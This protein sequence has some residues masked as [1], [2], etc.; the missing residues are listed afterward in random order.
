MSNSYFNDFEATKPTFDGDKPNAVPEDITME[1]KLF[2]S[3]NT[4]DKVYLIKDGRKHWVMTLEVLTALGF[5]LGDEAFVDSL[6]NFVSG[7]PIKLSTVDQ[8]K[9]GKPTVL[10]PILEA[11]EE[12]KIDLV[13][14]DKIIIP[15]HEPEGTP[16]VIVEGLT[17][18]II[19][20]FI[21][22]YQ[23]LHLTG[24]C[25]GQ[26]E[27]HTDRLKTPYE[28][29]LVSNGGMKID[30]KFSHADKFIEN[31]ENL[32]FA[33][34]VNQGIRVAQGEFVVIMNNDIKVYEHW[35]EDM[36]EGLKY[37]DL[38]AAIPMYSREDPWLRGVDSKKLREEQMKLPIEES[39]SDFEDFS[40]VVVKR[41]VF[42]EIG[43][44]DERYFYS[45]E[46]VDFKRRMKEKGLTYA[47]SKRVRTHHVGSCTDF[48]DKPKVMDQSKQ[49]FAEKWGTK[50]GLA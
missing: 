44:F 35:L 20:A 18:I 21:N 40:C 7:E 25:L 16:H 13:E 12:P 43:V 36:L 23:M 37:K 24:D 17:S 5:K 45:C 50:E 19:P 3:K 26:I 22:S 46:D 42:D 11:K 27:E 15:A 49:K 41:L 33:K 29:I 34:A 1:G 38:V 6:S 47:S 2:R 4:G 8:Y 48:E 32:G 28:I 31:K 10:D 14:P 39:L 30:P 9:T